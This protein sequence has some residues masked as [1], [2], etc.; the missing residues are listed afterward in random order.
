[1]P[2][3]GNLIEAEGHMVRLKRTFLW[4]VCVL[5]MAPCTQA[6][7]DLATAEL[8]MRK[9]GVWEQ[10]GSLA[11]QIRTGI[12]AALAQSGGNASPSEIDR[13]SQAVAFAYSADRLRSV[14][15]A[16][17]ARGLNAR[18]VPELRRWYDTATGQTISKM[19]EAETADQSDPGTVIKEG[20]V[21]LAKLPTRRR[22]LLDELVT[23]TEE[24]EMMTQSAVN[25]V[26]AIHKGARSVSPGLPGP[27][28]DEL[29]KTLEAQ[30]NQIFQGFVALSLASSAKT[31]ASL[32]T[33]ELSQYVAFLK[34]E[35]GRHFSDLVNRAVD[36]A[37]VD[38]ATEFGRS[39]P[40]IKDPSTKQD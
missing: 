11:P 5:L 25:I 12:M 18:H 4:G 10:L 14:S 21:L 30:R 31:Y 34:S 33:E 7:P 39:L 9:S 32:P 22:T 38:A 3:G 16:A 20:E 6:Q 40:S 24:A 2:T 1:V 36:A 19:E 37:L 35:A 26:L 23:E 8:L 29:R 15:L 28:E 13:V 17:I 27:S